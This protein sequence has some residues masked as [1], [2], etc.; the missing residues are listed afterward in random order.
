MG[1]DDAGAM[2]MVPIT[3]AAPPIAD[4]QG[5]RGQSDRRKSGRPAADVDDLED[6]DLGP[7][8]L[9]GR[10]PA[11]PLVEALVRW[12]LTHPVVP[13][14]LAPPRLDA[15]RR[16]YLETCTPAVVIPEG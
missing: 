16:A 11:Q 15:V 10:D 13:I 6:E 8:S 7:M 9:N 4:R 12:H 14:E 5:R 2:A 1:A 3:A